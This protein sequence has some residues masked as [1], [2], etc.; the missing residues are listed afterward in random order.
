MRKN[1]IAKYQQKKIYTF[2]TKYIQRKVVTKKEPL[3][4]FENQS[5]LFIS[6]SSP[7]TPG[8]ILSGG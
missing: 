2:F 6:P 1:Y 5:L 8:I 7:F 3:E 4:S